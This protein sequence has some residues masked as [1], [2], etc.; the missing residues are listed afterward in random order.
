MYF[1]GGDVTTV[2]GFDFPGEIS[3]E[4]RFVLRKKQNHKI[5]YKQKRWNLSFL[6]LV[7]VLYHSFPKN[8]LAADSETVDH[9]QQYC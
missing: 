8:S 5:D 6:S 7:L 3:T 9:K 1:P 4:K 2:S